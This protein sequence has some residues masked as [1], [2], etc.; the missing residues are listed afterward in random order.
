MNLS[1][2]VQ[3][4]DVLAL[5]RLYQSLP[6][7]K[8]QIRR[9]YVSGL[10]A[11]SCVLGAFFFIPR[12]ARLGLPLLALPI[13]SAIVVVVWSLTYRWMLK[14]ADHTF[15]AARRGS[16]TGPHKMTLTPEGVHEDRPQG[17]VFHRWGVVKS[18]LDWPDHLFIHLGNDGTYVIPKRDLAPAEA[19]L[20]LKTATDLWDA[21][22]SHESK[23]RLLRNSSLE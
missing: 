17:T 18:V 23:G 15:V 2:E 13:L 20:F 14:H 12:A 22:M 19:S 5:R 8:K 21:S 16:A 11:A 6:E 3:D 7:G 4:A 1:Y 10:T 9:E